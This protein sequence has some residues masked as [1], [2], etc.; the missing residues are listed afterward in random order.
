MPRTINFLGSVALLVSS[1]TGPSLVV[2]PLLFQQAGW[3]TPLL[4]FAAISL[5]SGA[6]ALFVVEVM[7][8][9][10]GNEIFQASVEFTTIAHLFLGKRWH[11]IVQGL[12]Y[13][14]MQTLVIASLLE[15]F[16]SIDDFL[17]GVAQKTCAV[18][19][20]D[21]W[22]CVNQ[23]PANGSSAFSG[24][25]LGSFGTL[26]TISLI[27]PLSL[28]H[29][30]DNIIFQVVSFIVLLGI[31]I[32]WIVIF[33][34]KGFNIDRTPV[35]GHDQSTVAG[36]VLSNFSFVTT[37][38][39]W[40][41]NTHPS[42]NIRLAVWTSIFISCLIYL[43]I[44]W[45]GGL[46]LVFPSNATL[47]QVL[48]TDTGHGMLSTVA[49]VSSYM[50]PLAVL[51]TSIP[52]FT[53]VIRYNLLRG[54]ICSNKMAIFWSAIFPWFIAIPFQ[55][56]GGLTTILNWASLV[57]TSPSN[58]LVPFILF[59]VSKNHIA[60][61]VLDPNVSPARP[62]VDEPSVPVGL[63]TV[64]GPTMG[65]RD[66][67]P[68]VI[69]TDSRYLDTSG[70]DETEARISKEFEE[71]GQSELDVIPMAVMNR[72]SAPSR[73]R[74]YGQE[75][76]NEGGESSIDGGT[77]RPVLSL[78]IA[79]TESHNQRRPSLSV[80]LSRSHSIIHSN[81]GMDEFLLMTP[82]SPKP[83]PRSH[84]VRSELSTRS[85]RQSTNTGMASPGRTPI[86]AP[87]ML[88]ERHP[89]AGSDAPLV[90]DARL[91][92]SP[93]T[94]EVPMPTFK[95]FP[96]L[97]ADSFIRSTRISIAGFLFASALVLTAIVYDIVQSARGSSG[98]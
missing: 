23:I 3:L 91:S 35:V 30:V 97:S 38:P 42:V 81:T 16:Q 62:T 75:V 22:V 8:S 51:I 89:S 71:V 47:L 70:T 93:I 78:D 39:A 87:P 37:I 21:G 44:G 27:L 74:Y 64:Q 52:V 79:A 68:V 41:N 49:Q 59:I 17:I 83:R 98:G 77:D 69:I 9:I 95:A 25:I 50:F 33:A 12:L 65:P 85:S 2:I 40:V 57:F 14:A 66:N 63:T 84:S 36:F 1:I 80:S 34:I 53:I 90:T 15:S 94:G 82:T 4:T 73:H 67:V 11:L 29:L 61:A 88:R 58:L 26:I 31:T 72:V 24:H 86:G 48:A 55:T 56:N 96:C 32:I 43:F 28:I 7:T 5:L 19:F 20:T 76:L 6:A 18:S 60:S 54:N 92:V 13:L 45:M 46:A 10:E